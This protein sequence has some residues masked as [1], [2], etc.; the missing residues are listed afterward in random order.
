MKKHAGM[1]LILLTCACGSSSKD[2]TS[3]SDTGKTG[4]TNTTIGATVKVNVNGMM[5]PLPF[6]TSVQGADAAYATIVLADPAA[7]LANP[8]GTPTWIGTAAINPNAC[9]DAGCPFSIANVDLSSL[10][11]GMAAG[12]IDSRLS[13]DPNTATLYP[14][15]TGVAQ[16][17]V[18]AGITAGNVNNVVAFAVSMEG[19]ALLGNATTAGAAALKANGTFIGLALDGNLNPA[20]GATLT[21]TGYLGSK[22][23]PA[24]D[25]NGMVTAEGTTTTGPTSASGLIVASPPTAT[26]A[27]GLGWT[28]AVTGSAL[29]YTV[30]AEL[31]TAPGFALIVPFPPNA[32]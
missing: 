28:L 19:F 8:N 14:I 12:V 31:G 18:T 4:D 27:I 25:G 11:I 6:L 7:I 32:P 29:T 3:G 20:A 17:S 24:L 13:T 23:Y 2:D 30:P 21:T 15:F 10:T 1:W 5:K 9:T 22:W 16:P 26:V